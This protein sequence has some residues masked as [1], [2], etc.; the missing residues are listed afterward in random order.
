MH[1]LREG[2]QLAELM[3][4]WACG[5]TLV[6]CGRAPD[7]HVM[8][9][10]SFASVSLQPPTVLVCVNRAASMSG[11]IAGE[12]GQRFSVSLLRAGQQELALACAGGQEEGEAR[13]SGAKW[14]DQDG[15]P[16]L[17]E[18]MSALLCRRVGMHQYGTHLVVVGEVQA[19]WDSGRREPLLYADRQFAGL[20]SP[21]SAPPG[22][23]PPDG[24]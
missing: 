18:A 23:A 20:A 14:N 2:G 10:S 21:G 11:A 22:S 5:V 6:A 24:A 8:T 17:A 15:T 13:F 4:G 16:W 1:P 3:R 12:G 7:R 19:C 9:V